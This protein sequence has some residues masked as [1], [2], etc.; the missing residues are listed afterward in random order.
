MGTVVKRLITGATG[1]LGV[2]LVECLLQQEA[3]DLRV[4]VRE[5]SDRRRLDSVLARY[6]DASVE[7]AIGTLDSVADAAALLGDVGLVCHLAAAKRGTAGDIARS[8]LGGSRHLLDAIVASGREI[9]VVLVSSFGVYGTADLEPDAPLT[10][11]TPLEMHPAHRDA[12]SHAK[13]EQERL[14]RAYHARHRVPLSVV[15]P[16]VVYG[17]EQVEP[18]QRVGLRLGGFLLFAGGNNALPLTYVD[19]CAQAICLVAERARFDGDTYNVVD[20]DEQEGT[21]VNCRA[22]L[23]RYRASGHRVLAIPLHWTALER[24]AR[25]LARLRILSRN[26]LPAFPSAYQVRTMW[27]PQRFDGAAL[28]ALGHVP[29]IPTQEALRRTFARTR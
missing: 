8:T 26:R 11:M 4:L 3:Q 15:R 19:N 14:F 17:P 23:D 18:S 29:R 13:L 1:F 27:K 5:G 12:Y 22:Y 20:E 9:R 2:A 21:V 25:V 28:R 24:V 7:V 6:P 16:G 10:E